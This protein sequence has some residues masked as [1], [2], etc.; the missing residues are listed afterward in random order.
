MGQ[1]DRKGEGVVNWNPSGSL[2]RLKI[3]DQI[4]TTNSQTCTYSHD[5]LGRVSSANCGCSLWSQTFTYDPFGN[6]TKTV[7][8]GCTSM[9]FQVN[10]D[11]TNYTNQITSGPFSYTSTSD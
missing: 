2:L 10:Y 3:T 4:N 5:D 8:N 9:S 1:K 11:Y 7:P 6:I